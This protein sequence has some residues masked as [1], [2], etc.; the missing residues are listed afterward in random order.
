[1]GLP[2]RILYLFHWELAQLNLRHDEF[3][4]HL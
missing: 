3:F 4:C 1:M 2:D